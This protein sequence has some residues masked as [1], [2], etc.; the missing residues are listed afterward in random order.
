MLILAIFIEERINRERE[1]EL[2]RDRDREREREKATESERALFPF[3]ILWQ[4]Q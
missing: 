4:E 1:G 3:F 2:E